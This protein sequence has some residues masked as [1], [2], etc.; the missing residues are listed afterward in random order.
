M[1]PNGENESR[2]RIPAKAARCLREFL[3]LRDCY[4][5]FGALWRY[6]QRMHDEAKQLHL[7]PFSP[8]F[9]AEIASWPLDAEDAKAWAGRET[10]FPVS[11]EQVVRWHEDADI[12]P[13]AG[14]IDDKPIAYGELWIDRSEDEVELA[15]I[16][17]DP[18]YRG[19]GFGRKFVQALLDEC[20]RLRQTEI[21]LRVCPANSA[22]LRCYSIAGFKPVSKSEEIKWNK[23]QPIEYRWMRHG[24]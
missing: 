17:V 5:G 7:T 18:A 15:R 6:A 21:V 23:G 3:G 24:A 10:V 11:P 4:A 8:E 9:A 1:E 2:H 14:I 19:I 13:F 16:I 22:A 12:R 20:T